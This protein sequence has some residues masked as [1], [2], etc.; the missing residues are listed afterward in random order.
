MLN[1]YTYLFVTAFLTKSTGIIVAA[2]NATT[3]HP[4]TP[5]GTQLNILLIHLNGA[6]GTKAALIINACTA[7]IAKNTFK[8]P[9]FSLPTLG[10][11][12]KK[13]EKEEKE[14]VEEED[15][16]EED[17]VEEVNTAVENPLDGQP[18]L[19]L[20]PIFE[21][22]TYNEGIPSATSAPVEII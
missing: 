7:T 22:V 8:K 11:D 13:E 12:E 2:S 3:P 5:N 17:N 6:S 15:D 9:V 20:E 18:V 4:I 10:G 21:G 1:Y 14:A 19:Q 16:V